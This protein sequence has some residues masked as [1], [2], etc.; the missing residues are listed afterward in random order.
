MFGFGGVRATFFRWH[1]FRAVRGRVALSGFVVLCAATAEL[2]YA[3]RPVDFETRVMQE[4]EKTEKDAES[5][6]HP[7]LEK[8]I[9]QLM[10]QIPDLKGLHAT[11]DQ[12]ALKGIL[13]KA[14]AE[15]DEFFKNVVDLEAHEEIKQERE[16]A[17]GAARGRKPV[18]DNYLIVRSVDGDR[19]D[20]DEFRMD[21]QG[22]RMGDEDF[23]RGFLVTSG[24]ALICRQFSSDFQQE[25]SF[26]YLG[27][28]KVSGRETYVVAFAQLPIEDNFTITLKGPNGD[29]AHMLTQGIAWVDKENFHI[30]RMR[31]D[32]LA[33]KQSAGLEEQT[34]KVNFEE[35]HFTD[36]ATPLWLPRD[37]NVYV[38][39]GRSA[40]RVVEL[41]FRN[42]HHYTDYRRYR[43]TTKILPAQ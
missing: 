9:K 21:E 30:V 36:I 2:G 39:L 23:G 34:T 27:E 32:L 7:Y 43:V 40:Q 14:G 37:V 15:V 31:T 35:V 38:R 20:F 16:S 24:F 17:F 8:P 6:I 26:K 12:Q 29:I 3:R 22:N 41:E 11:E 13:E 33:G 18:Q 1:W 28:Q 19:T 10:K 4:A 5:G 42:T 25:S